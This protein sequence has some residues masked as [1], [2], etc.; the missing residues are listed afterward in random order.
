GVFARAMDSAAGSLDTLS[1]VEWDAVAQSL[2][3]LLFAFTGQLVASVSDS[4][5]A[6]KTAIMNRICQTIERK[7]DD[8]ELTLVRVAQSEGISE[9]YLQKLFEGAGDNFTHYV[10]ERRLQRAW[11]DLA[12]PAEAHHTI[13][14]IAYRYGFADSAHFSRTFRA[15]FGLSPREFRQ[16]EAGRA[17]APGATLRRPRW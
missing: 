10:R 4:G 3:D 16:Q 11:S 14:E 7:L 2:A 13:S 5:S 17:A 12:S 8:A 6:T 9:R 15:R 1:D